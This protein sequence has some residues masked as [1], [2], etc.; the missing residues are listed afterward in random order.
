MGSHGFN[1]DCS[2]MFGGAAQR[3]S[4]L[5]R[6]ALKGT[7]R[8]DGASIGDAFIAKCACHQF[9]VVEMARDNLDS[10]SMAVPVALATANSA[11]Y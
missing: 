11:N 2:S 4:A 9:S 8:H 3:H 7:E 6:Y 1:F 5:L 10:S